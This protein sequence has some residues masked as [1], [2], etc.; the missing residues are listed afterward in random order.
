MLKSIS[1]RNFQKHRKLKIEF[2]PGITTFV[3]ASDR[4]KSAILRA[5]RWAAFN[6]TGD[7]DFL[8]WGAKF[9]KVELAVDDHTIIRK[10]KGSTNLYKLDDKEPFRAIGTKVPEEIA[11]ILNVSDLNVQRQIDPPFWFTKSAGEVSRELNSI[12]NLGLIDSTLANL[13]S[14]LRKARSVAVI[15]NERL[16][17]AIQQKTKLEWVEAADKALKRYEAKDEA[18]EELR[19]K[20]SRANDLLVLAA[21]YVKDRDNAALA[22][23]DAT[24]ALRPIEQLTEKLEALKEQKRQLKDLM[25]RYEDAEEEQCRYNTELEEAKKEEKVLMKGLCPICNQPLTLKQ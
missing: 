10:K 16:Q 18:L 5:L 20:R 14:S 8:R 23:L 22:A 6:R 9:A 12:I 21:N 11:S 3:G 7:R 24:N 2:D 4:G 17:E 25:D 15:T 13:Q 19:L 1:I